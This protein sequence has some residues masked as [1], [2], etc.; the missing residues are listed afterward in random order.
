MSPVGVELLPFR[1]ESASP[2]TSLDNAQPLPAS[3]PN[4]RAGEPGYLSSLWGRPSRV[5]DCPFV[6]CLSLP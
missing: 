5:Q 1:A 4:E 2:E 3:V 6:L